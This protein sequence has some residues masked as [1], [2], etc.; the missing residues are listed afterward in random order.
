[1]FGMSIY[2]Q[3]LIHT[4]KSEKWLFDF[5]S[6]TVIFSEYKYETNSEVYISLNIC[7]A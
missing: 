1:M 2:L 3:L 4:I 6:T 5:F 7:I